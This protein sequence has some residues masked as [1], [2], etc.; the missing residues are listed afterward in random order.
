MCP[1]SVYM[2]QTER[3]EEEKRA[4]REELD[5]T[6]GEV[7]AHVMLCLAGDYRR[8]GSGKVWMGNKKSSG[9]GTGR[10]CYE[11]WAG[12]GRIFL[13]KEKQP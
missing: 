3:A 9:P 1:M 13:P 10:V 2:P 11:K 12:C 6:V 7:V 4:F 8:G 5:Q